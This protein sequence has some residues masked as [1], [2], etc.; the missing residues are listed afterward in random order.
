MY[1]NLIPVLLIFLVS[2]QQADN[3]KQTE[4]KLIA[5]EELGIIT[6]SVFSENTLTPAKPVYSTTAPGESQKIE[7]AFENAPP[8]IPHNTEGFFPITI[9]KNICLTCHM[10]ALAEAAKSIPLPETHFTSLRPQIEKEGDLYH[11]YDLD[12]QVVKSKTPDVLSHAYFSCNQCHVPLA[13][14]TVDIENL[15]TPEFREMLSK[16]SST[17]SDN[18]S[19]GVR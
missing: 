7:R 2:C 14:V 1:R 17:L 18:V 10:P 12:N 15:F 3:T 6:A 16:S 5:D 19:E 9:D 11:L 4:S 8:M 13:E